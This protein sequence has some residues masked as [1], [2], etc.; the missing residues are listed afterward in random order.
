VVCLL[1][2]QAINEESELTSDHLA[3]YLTQRGGVQ[4]S[5]ADGDAYRTGRWSSPDTGA[6]CDID[7]GISPVEEDHL[8]P[9]K[10]YDGWRNLDLTIHVPL[11]GPHWLCVEALQWIEQLLAEFPQVRTLD[12]E[13]TRDGEQDG[14]TR[15]NRP[16][17]LASWERLHQA[18]LQGRTVHL[19]MNRLTSVC[20]WRYRR[21]RARGRSTYPEL[22]WPDALA[23]LDTHH[24]C[25]RS[26]VILPQPLRAMALPPV[27]LIIVP[28]EHEPIII[29]AA[30]MSAVAGAA[31]SCAQAQ[32]LEPSPAV[33]ECLRT[34]E[35]YPR[36]RFK[37]LGDHDW[38]D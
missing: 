9:A 10:S 29:E 38:S 1:F 28:T 18:Q 19:R 13:D 33:D 6:W 22:W 34:G 12:T 16:R 5:G 7:V 30:T 15:W 2:Y 11:S 8:H 31:L 25:V 21:E 36:A 32:R 26:A 20:L 3:D 27:E 17:I 23:V 35:Q 14:P 4:L 37:A 24:H